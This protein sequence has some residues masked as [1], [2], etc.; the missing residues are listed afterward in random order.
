M[1]GILRKNKNGRPTLFI[2]GFI[3]IIIIHR[4]FDDG[5]GSTDL[6]SPEPY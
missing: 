6:G 1:R 3:N 5:G 4:N 2:K